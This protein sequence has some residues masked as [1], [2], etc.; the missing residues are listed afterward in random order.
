MIVE[1]MICIL[2]FWMSSLLALAQDSD[3]HATT[4]IKVED[5]TRTNDLGRVLDIRIRPN[6]VIAAGKG[7]C[8]YFTKPYPMRLVFG[9]GSELL[10][11][12]I[13]FEGEKMLPNSIE[14]QGSFSAVYAHDLDDSESVTI[15]FSGKLQSEA[16]Q[17]RGKV[18]INSAQDGRCTVSFKFSESLKKRT[19]SSQTPKK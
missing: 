18:S 7:A 1:A 12:E 6:E 14:E 17:G 2:V 9:S 16:I 10:R 3:L 15:S 13:Q 11:F 19:K 5:R 8:R 4:S